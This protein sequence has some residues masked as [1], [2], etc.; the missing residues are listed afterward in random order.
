M[1]SD[2]GEVHP[3]DLTSMENIGIAMAYLT[4][5]LTMSLVT[6]PMNIY[7]V[8]TLNAEPDLQGTINILQTLPW[9]LKI[10]VGFLSDSVPVFGAHRKPY[11]LI[12]TF[13]YAVSWLYYAQVEAM[14]YGSLILLS[15]VTFVS[16]MGLITI[17]VMAD[18]MCVERSKFEPEIIK[19]Q[20]QATCYSSRFGG[21]VLGA[22]LGTLVTEKGGLFYLDF[23]DICKLNGVL[24]IVLVLPFCFSMRE[25]F[26]RR[27]VSEEVLSQLADGSSARKE[28]KYGSILRAERDTSISL[29]QSVVTL[30]YEYGY[31]PAHRRE[32]TGNELELVERGSAQIYMT[33][34]VKSSRRYSRIIADNM[35][36]PRMG[37]WHLDATGTRQ[38]GERLRGQPGVTSPLQRGGQ[39]QN[40]P[41]PI[42][43]QGEPTHASGAGHVRGNGTRSDVPAA[44]DRAPSRED[45]PLLPPPHASPRSGG[46][47]GSITDVG[48]N[49]TTPLATTDKSPGD[50]GMGGEVRPRAVTNP[51]SPSFHYGASPALYSL[52]VQSNKHFSES[53]GGVH[54][55]TEGDL[56][57]TIE[58][59]NTSIVSATSPDMGGGG[60]VPLP[61][62]AVVSTQG[63]GEDEGEVSVSRQIQ[64][65][66]NTVQLRAVWRPM[67]F[68]YIFNLLQIPNVAWQSYL[69][70]T[71]HFESWI[72][73]LSVLFGSIMTFVGILIYKYYLF[74]VTWRSI[75]IWSCFLTA[76]FSL[77]Q[78]V[79]IFQINQTVLHMGNYLFSMGDDVI[80]AYISGIQFLPVCIMYMK[81]CP[82]GA[83]GA[84]YAILTTFGNIALVVANSLGNTMSKVWDVSNS[85]LRKGDV[86]G[87][88]KLSLTTSVI[89]LVPLVLL[90]LLPRDKKEQLDLGRSQVRSKIGGAI[91]LAVLA[92]SLGYCITHSVVELLSI[93]SA[94]PILP[95]AT[96]FRPKVPLH[97]HWA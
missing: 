75:Y 19:G 85:A 64:E 59:V 36:N 78:L 58:T 94:H 68:V 89:P 96:G 91:F 69:Q 40:S 38:A 71:L 13:V 39:R 83:E 7:L 86:S 87:L 5:G 43:Y 28:A 2:R 90:F 34:P 22:V 77:M 35:A 84:S 95:E 60:Y 53:V 47:T 41:L 31:V 26:Y 25:K 15:S 50:S 37:E 30:N 67:A 63:M 27:D 54:V 6:T 33:T 23:A 52:D 81:L 61:E 14:G 24:P 65:I 8:N 51:L 74:N 32:S 45:T 12:G 42:S 46:I 16:T 73:G 66:W 20:M 48:V 57:Q 1:I 11:L 72:L 44:D 92:L 29:N 76:F 10:L 49:N 17:D 56:D 80:T 3:C 70:L 9:S 4:V 97:H 93:Y 21:A 82:S 79:L 88:W 55:L 62:D 18:T